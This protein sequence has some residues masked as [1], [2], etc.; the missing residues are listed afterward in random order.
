MK[1]PSERAF[2]IAAAAAW[3]VIALLPVLRGRHVRVWALAA[4]GIALGV[5]LAAPAWLAP[6][7]SAWMRLTAILGRIMNPVVMVILFFGIITPSATIL[8]LL[9][10]DPLRLRFRTRG[11]S[12]WIRRGPPGPASES[13]IDQY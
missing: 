6:I 9:G 10:R 13:M 11:P 12:Y 3:A 8:R 4:S 7:N 1:R 2:G 5:A